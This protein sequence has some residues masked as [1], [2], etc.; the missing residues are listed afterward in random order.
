MVGPQKKVKNIIKESVLYYPACHIRRYAIRV[1]SQSQK[2]KSTLQNTA[3]IFP[4]K[5]YMVNP[6]DINTMLT[7]SFENRYYRTLSPVMGGNWDLNTKDMMDYDLFRSIYRHF[8]KNISWEDT[9]FYPRVK[10]EIENTNNWVKWGCKNFREFQSRL[11]DL[12]SLHS[13]IED[14]GYKTQRELKHSGGNFKDYCVPPEYHEVTVH[15]SRSG[16]LIFHEGRHR[17]AIAQALE[18]DEI[19]VRIMV[20]HNKWQSKR[21]EI[22]QNNEVEDR[23]ILKHPDIRELV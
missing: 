4:L 20:R 12:D 11:N 3:P 18:L 16:K 6:S 1:N 5:L 13:K 8:T 21:T 7:D 9:D 15:I 14:S 22:H 17:L 2:I 23:G 10:K 19:P